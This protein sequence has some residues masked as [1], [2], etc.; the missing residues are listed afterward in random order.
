M[1]QEEIL[2]ILKEK[3]EWIITGEI[4]T[5]LNQSRSTI[6]QS[7]RKLLKQGEVEKRVV[8]RRRKNINQWKIKD[9][10]TQTNSKKNI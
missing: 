10:N 1:G 2:N 3:K 4:S 5:I 8:P 9:E 6:N 7:L